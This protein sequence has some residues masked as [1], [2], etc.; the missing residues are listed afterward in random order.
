MK[1]G[2]VLDVA[3]V[4]LVVEPR[5][6]SVTRVPSEVF[7]SSSTWFEVVTEQQRFEVF[8]PRTR[9]NTVGAEAPRLTGCSEVIRCGRSV[10]SSRYSSR[11][12]SRGPVA[13]SASRAAAQMHL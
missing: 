11:R 12:R 2:V 6:H 3:A 5:I 4:V 9:R 7:R 13:P 10:P 1:S 8:R